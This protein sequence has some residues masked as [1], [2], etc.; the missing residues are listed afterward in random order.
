MITI[1]SIISDPSLSSTAKLVMIHVLDLSQSS[2]STEVEIRDEAIAMSLGRAPR[3]VYRS[4]RELTRRGFL[5]HG[6]VNRKT[7]TRPVEVNLVADESFDEMLSH[8]G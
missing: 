8:F 6:K 3:E 5:K 2:N 1:N 4:I 7:R